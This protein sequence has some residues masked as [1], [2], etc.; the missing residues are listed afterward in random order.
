MKYLPSSWN[1]ERLIISDVKPFE[2]VELQKLY[3][4]SRYIQEWD[5]QENDVNYVKNCVEQGNL[6]GWNTSQL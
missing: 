1:S 4:T 3:D 6:P 2:I 5:G